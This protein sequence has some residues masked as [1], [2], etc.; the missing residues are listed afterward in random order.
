MIVKNR[1]IFAGFLVYTFWYVLLFIL[2]SWR[3]GVLPVWVLTDYP[4]S[5]FVVACGA[6]VGLLLTFGVT[7]IRLHQREIIVRQGE[8]SRGATTSLG[9][10][11]GMQ[12]VKEGHALATEAFLVK[13]H[14]RKWWPLIAGEHPAH[15]AAMEAVMRVFA[16]EPK[17]P[18]SPVP[19]GHSG[20]TLA[21]HSLAV[22]DSILKMGKD[23][24]Y[25][26]QYTRQGELQVP[27]MDASKPHH[28]FGRADVGLLALAGL[29]HD[30]GK[31]TCYQPSG[32]A[33]GRTV[34]VT[35]VKPNHDT[36]GAK[37]LRC[38]PEI[39]A[40]P[41]RDRRAV[42]LAVGFYHHAGSISLAE[43]IDDRMRSLAELLI[44]ADVATGVAEGDAEATAA[45]AAA[46]TTI[47]SHEDTGGT[48]PDG[49]AA[50][51]EKPQS[52]LADPS[53]PRE[54]K[55]FLKVLSDPNAIGGNVSVQMDKIGYKYDDRLWLHDDL[56]RGKLA[57]LPD[58]TDVE[59]YST[60]KTGGDA[61]TDFSRALMGQLADR[62][63]LERKYDGKVYPPARAM[64]CVQASNKKRSVMKD[65]FIIDA[66]I[67]PSTSTLPNGIKME[68][69]GPRWKD[70]AAKGA[71]PVKPAGLPTAEE[72]AAEDTGFTDPD[73]ATADSG[74]VKTPT[75]TKPTAKPA[76][77]TQ[78]ALPLP[79]PDAQATPAMAPEASPVTAVSPREALE[80]LADFLDA[81]AKGLERRTI[82]TQTYVIVP[83]DAV[84]LIET[85]DQVKAVVPD[86][87]I[88]NVGRGR[89]VLVPSRT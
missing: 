76:S 63:L 3:R 69:I 50:Q 1:L 11:P 35:E 12:A 47:G 31:V 54:L 20:R 86:K 78:Q 74:S 66:A 18:A 56:V 68:I 43:N 26:G 24:R 16:T 71:E 51:P 84:S 30:I 72:S 6:G 19:G 75:T 80:R 65:I 36:E 73:A 33:E 2:L 58:I 25:T 67:L 53:L 60:Y 41:Y 29:A 5:L 22:A 88:V 89:A 14:H 4:L 27:L 70:K 34:P 55:L 83:A 39:L 32:P 21:E 13:L 28:S 46:E 64:F 40:L 44:A 59:V 15:A 82:G 49:D 8:T 23:W 79:V 45:A 7:S 57:G 81:A 38:M 9:E 62:N 42:L 10:L 17:L 52:L 85:I 77:V 87:A 37:L 61:P 48:R